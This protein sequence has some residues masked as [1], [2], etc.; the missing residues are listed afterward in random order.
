VVVPRDELEEL[1]IELDAGAGVED[2]RVL[3]VDEIRRDHFVTRVSEDVLEV[4]FARALHRLADF[5]VAR[6][7]HRLHGEV[8]DRHRG[9][10]HAERHAGE[11]ALHF[12]TYQRGRFR[13]AGTRGDDVDRGG[14]AA[15]PILL[16]RTIDGLLRRGVGV[17]GRHEA[18]LDAETFLQQNVHERSE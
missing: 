14:T 18:I 2:G 8:D 9:R 1:W 11:L 15:L 13:G 3:V 17:D 12:G 4:G 16:R 7:L 10:R 6:R 5:L